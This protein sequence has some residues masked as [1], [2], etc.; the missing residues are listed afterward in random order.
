M[1][2]AVLVECNRERIST[3][4]N[5]VADWDNK[6][7]VVARCGSMKSATRL[8]NKHRP[9]IVFIHIH[10]DTDIK[11][12]VLNRINVTHTGLI[13]VLIQEDRHVQYI[14]AC[15]LPRSI[16]IGELKELVERLEAKTPGGDRSKTRQ[17]QVWI[18]DSKSNWIPIDTQNIVYCT[19]DNQYTHFHIKENNKNKLRMM[20]DL[21]IKP[22]RKGLVKWTSA[23]GIGE[24]EAVLEHYGFCRI[25]N[26]TIVNLIHIY[27][28]TRDGKHKLLL[29]TGD[30]LDIS[31]EK[32]KRFLALSGLR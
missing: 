25:H 5:L 28:Y 7:Q 22:D 12:G 14:N 3:V 2:K 24:W 1:I 18:N 11:L 15:T 6:I 27:K 19:S 20:A 16:E 21:G 13:F 8:I 29:S 17:G 30:V 10:P 4:N 26:R 32:K 23:R 31:K 9:D